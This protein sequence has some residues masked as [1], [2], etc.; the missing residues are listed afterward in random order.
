MDTD[1]TEHKT[2]RQALLATAKGGFD[3]TKIKTT[4]DGNEILWDSVNDCFVYLNKEVDETEP[5]YIPN[6]KKVDRKVESYEYWTISDTT[7]TSATYSTYLGNNNLTGTVTATTGV[8]VGENSGITAI[9][10]ETNSIQNVVINTNGGMLTVNAGKSSVTHYGLADKV[11]VEN[12]DTASYHEAGYVTSYIDAQNGHIVIESTASVSILA[13]NGDITVEQKS[14]SELFKVVPVG[15]GKTIDSTKVKTLPGV[16]VGEAVETGDLAKMKYGGGQGISEHPYELYTAAHLAAFA[17]DVNESKLSDVYVKLLADVNIGNMAWT[18]IGNALAPF[19]GSFDGGNHTI[20]GLTNKGYTP[21]EKLW[22]VTSNA[23]NSGV[24]Y[25]LFGVVGAKTGAGETVTI[26]NLKLDN[27]DINIADSNNIGALIGA[28]SGAADIGTN[29]KANPDANFD[30]NIMNITTSGKI[31]CNN[32]TGAS[33]GGIIGKAYTGKNNTNNTAGILSIENC[34]NNIEFSVNSENGSDVKLGGIIGYSQTFHINLVNCE[35]KGNMNVT[36]GG[37][38]MGG[39]MSYT[40]T[41]KQLFVQGCKNSATM[42]IADG[43]TIKNCGLLVS[44]WKIADGMNCS[45][46]GAKVV[47]KLV[48][49][50]SSLNANNYYNY[51]KIE[52]ASATTIKTKNAK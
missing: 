43:V 13:V 11:V 27:V 48:G 9:T 21:E 49:N 19:V 32:A 50:T 45:V 10:Y 17:K 33:I 36:S 14:G 26:Q 34:T 3:V 6:S 20:S 42:T 7:A 18:P 39:I 2:M 12:I 15:S 29:Q 8:D 44:R 22:G 51:T 31:V 16:K 52:N 46:E 1:N 4:A 30:L 35:N 24:P 37:V 41:G 25:G 47:A 23:N 40:D 28:D 5:Q 38:Y